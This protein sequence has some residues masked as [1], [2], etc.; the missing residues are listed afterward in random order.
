VCSL[1]ESDDALVHAAIPDSSSLYSGSDPETYYPNGTAVYPEEFR[2]EVYI[3]PYLDQG[4]LQPEFT[5]KNTDWTYGTSYPIAVTLHQGTTEA[6]IRISL[7]AGK[8]QPPKYTR[9]F[10]IWIGVCS[11]FEHA[12]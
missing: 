11:D 10:L 9:V 3:P 7:V 1:G 2:I 6:S 5:I 12:R 8:P 4:R